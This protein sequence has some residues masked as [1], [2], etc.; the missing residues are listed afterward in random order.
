MLSE[1]E[2]KDTKL[3]WLNTTRPGQFVWHHSPAFSCDTDWCWSQPHVWFTIWRDPIDRIISQYFYVRHSDRGVRKESSRA[4]HLELDRG[5]VACVRDQAEGCRRNWMTAMMCG[6][7]PYCN[8][9]VFNTDDVLAQRAISTAESN[10]AR[11]GFVLRQESLSN[12][13]RV[14]LHK[15]L[16][17]TDAIVSPE[18]VRVTGPGTKA[19]QEDLKLPTAADG[20]CPRWFT[21]RSFCESQQSGAR[22]NQTVAHTSCISIDHCRSLIKKDPVILGVLRAANQ[23]DIQLTTL[24]MKRNA[25]LSDHVIQPHVS[26]STQCQPGSMSLPFSRYGPATGEMCIRCPVG[27]FRGAT[28]SRCLPC[29][30]NTAQPREGS[31]SCNIC[32]GMPAINADATL[33]GEMRWLIGRAFCPNTTDWAVETSLPVINCSAIANTDNPM[34]IPHITHVKSMS[35]G[36]TDLKTVTTVVSKGSLLGLHVLRRWPHSTPPC[37]HRLSLYAMMIRTCPGTSPRCLKTALLS[38]TRE[39]YCQP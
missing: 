20:S 32:E 37:F 28:D 33:V 25:E 4:R 19:T 11:F 22:P 16:P 5:I 34:K 36:T 12:D 7:A 21:R 15:V 31:T 17:G 30:I 38:A 2:K 13:L 29:P 23:L 1:D 8:Y 18:K 39:K 35:R 6:H 27:T 9:S 10:L 14:M 24:A 3:G 26:T